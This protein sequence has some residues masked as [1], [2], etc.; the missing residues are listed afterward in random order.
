MVSLISVS[1]RNAAERIQA[2]LVEHG[3]QAD[4]QQ[5][6]L[7]QLVSCS[8]TALVFIHIMVAETDLA[9]AGEILNA[10]LEGA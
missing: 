8:P 4:L 3:I 6:D 7:S 2:R 10:R 5:D 9:R 1:N